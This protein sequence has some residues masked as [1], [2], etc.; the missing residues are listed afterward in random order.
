MKI[1]VL[2]HGSGVYDGTEIQE[3]VLS[4]LALEEAGYEYVC[5]APDKNQHHVINHLTGDEMAETRNVMIESAR[6]A[7]GKIESL[8]V[9]HVDTIDALVMPGGFGTAKNITNWAFAGAEGTIDPLVRDFIVALVKAKKPI[10]ALCMS[11]TTVAKAV[12]ESG[13]SAKLS[14]GT[15]AA[16]SPYGIAD[17]STGIE[18]TGASALM[19]TIQE[20][21]IDEENKIICAPCYMME[22]SLLDVRKNISQA[23]QQMDL[24]LKA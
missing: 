15:T 23:I 20:I 19:E 18:S 1:G 21:A 11:P 10:V 6:I 13:I 22:A 17:I 14:V 24:W 9:S 16:K 3:A 5:L 8:A 2:L 12:Q 4:L 7:R